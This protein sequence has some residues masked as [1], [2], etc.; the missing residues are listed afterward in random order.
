MTLGQ[1]FNYLLCLCA[2]LSFCEHYSSHPE[3]LRPGAVG[4]LGMD[5]H[6]SFLSQ[7]VGVAYH[8]V[9]CVIQDALLGSAP[10][11]GCCATLCS[12]ETAFAMSVP[13]KLTS[14]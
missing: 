5:V 6:E 10:L 11:A 9:S 7:A 2:L 12:L 8:E 13:L 1:S 14:F 4:L 3:L